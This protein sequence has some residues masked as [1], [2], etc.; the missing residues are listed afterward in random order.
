MC[1]HTAIYVS[2]YCKMC[3]LILLYMGP[4]T[5]VCVSSY[6]CICVLRLLYMCP[7]TAIHVSCR[8]NNIWLCGAW[9]GYGFHEDGIKSAV[10]VVTAMGDY[11]KSTC[12]SV[13]KYLLTSTKVRK[14]TRKAL[15]A[16]AFLGPPAPRGVLATRVVSSCSL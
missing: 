10:D 13:Q 8:Q 14:L 15:Q 3:V 6:S 12:L 7:H 4:H 5:A 2:S 9:C 1:P 16:S 11:Y